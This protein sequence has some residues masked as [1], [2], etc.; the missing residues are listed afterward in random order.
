M[1]PGQLSQRTRPGSSLPAPKGINLTISGPLRKL[2]VDR[3]EVD[4]AAR[5]RVLSFKYHSIAPRRDHH[6]NAA[7]RNW[8]LALIGGVTVHPAQRVMTLTVVFWPRSKQHRGHVPKLIPA[9][10]PLGDVVCF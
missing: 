4:Y 5:R 8:F 9:M 1:G 6:R 2:L 7:D 3:N 10:S